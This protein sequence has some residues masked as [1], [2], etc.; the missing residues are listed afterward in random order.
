MIL[1]H[2]TN[3]KVLSNLIEKT[4]QWSKILNLLYKIIIIKKF[5]KKMNYGKNF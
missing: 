3:L 1:K 5:T 4:F 2:S